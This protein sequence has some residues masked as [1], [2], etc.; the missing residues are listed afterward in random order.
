[1]KNL[2]S[3]PVTAMFCLA[4]LGACSAPSRDDQAVITPDDSIMTIVA[5]RGDGDGAEAIFREHCGSCHMGDSRISHSPSVWHLSSMPPRSI[6]SAMQSGKMREQAA[7]LSESEKIAVATWLTGTVPGEEDIPASAYCSAKT[8]N[9]D[10][11]IYSSGWGGNVN[12]T[13]YYPPSQTT[14][15]A[16]TVA[17]LRF[18]WAFAVPGSGE[19]RSK[20]AV[21]GDRLFFGSE[22]GAV[23]ALDRKSGC[24]H[25]VYNADAAIR[26]ALN[27]QVSEAGNLRIFFA[28]MRGTVHALDGDTGKALWTLDAASHYQASVTGSVAYHDNRLFIPFSSTEIVSTRD[29]DYPCCHSA[30]EVV[31]VDA[32]QGK[33]LWR[34]RTIEEPAVAHGENNIGSTSF[35]PSGAPV[36]SSP[37]VDAKRGVIYF[38]T[39][40]NFT[41]PATKTSDAIFALDM[42]TGGVAWRFQAT[43]NDVWNLDCGTQGNA[44]CPEAGPDLDFGM[45]PMLVT[46]RD[47]RE[48][49]IVGQKSGSMHALD[50]DQR[51]QLLWSTR[52]GRGGALGGIHWGMSTDGKLAFAPLADFPA[53]VVVEQ[54]PFHPSS[55]GVA[56]LD[57]T[58]G[59]L[60]WRHDNPAPACVE[61]DVSCLTGNSAATT[62]VPGAVFTGSMDGMIRA[63]SAHDGSNLWEFNTEREFATVNGVKGH[64]GSVE[65]PGPVVANDNLYVLSGY[66]TN[67]GTAGNLLLAFKL[68]SE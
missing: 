59:E 26:G 24:A 53:L 60:V 62:A 33:L 34:F 38:G 64:G 27:V 22:F 40:E 21:V 68:D 47:G 17:G 25:W 30:G 16:D 57:V 39:G 58:T 9:A 55:P 2:F 52:V 10:A 45:A 51:G 36:W 32:K 37:T 12:A 19:M 44:H 15:S 49:L 23:Y 65:G 6:L 66:T 46:R 50:P 5:S 3:A 28:D 29:R 61:D 11:T 35:G 14:L 13:G 8:G 41:H 4:L 7:A 48:V 20:P 67:L 63:I 56:A 31:A 43:A 1:M 54:Q 42:N 18:D